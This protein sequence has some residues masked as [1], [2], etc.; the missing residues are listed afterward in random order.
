MRGVAVDPV[1]RQTILRSCEW[2]VCPPLVSTWSL[3]MMKGLRWPL[4]GRSSHDRSE[5]GVIPSPPPPPS[6]S[7]SSGA[8]SVAQTDQ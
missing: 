1:R 5:Q 8:A 4:G 2:S 7:C 3:V 6:P